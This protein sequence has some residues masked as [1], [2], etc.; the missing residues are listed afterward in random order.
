MVGADK[1]AEH[2]KN[3]PWKKKEDP[4]AKAKEQPVKPSGEFKPAKG[5]NIDVRPRHEQENSTARWYVV[6]G[7][8]AVLILLLVFIIPAYR[9]Y[10]VYSAMKESGVPDQYFTNMQGLL[11]DKQSAEANAAS[12]SSQLQSTQD[13]LSSTKDDL[14]T[15]K[16]ELS[17]CKHDLADTKKKS[18]QL[19]NSFQSDN[20]K[21]KSDLAACTKAADDATKAHD[22]LVADS[23]RRICCI[24]RVENPDINAYSVVDNKIVCIKDGGTELK[25]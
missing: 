7:A 17:D 20:N 23:A 6:G 21:L 9:G 22:A 13:Q 4:W 14:T 12:Y 3:D 5:L 10:N 8:V 19:V 15:C 25:C 11:A 16:N 2:P 1:P 24:Q 18:E